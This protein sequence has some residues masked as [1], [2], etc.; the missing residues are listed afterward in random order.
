MPAVMAG[1]L[2]AYVFSFDNLVVSSFL[3]TPQVNTLPVYLY[4]S[5]QYGPSP[6]VYAA[7]TA[8]FVFTMLILAVAALLYRLVLRRGA[9]AEV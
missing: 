5:L 9:V 1:A 7:A 8:V 6:A 3:T 2:M 4:G